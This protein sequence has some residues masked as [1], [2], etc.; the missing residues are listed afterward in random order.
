MKF[1][2]DTA[3][4]EKIREYA[5]LG[6]VDGVTTN[7]SL[8]AK[9]GKDFEEVIKE[10][11]SIIKGPISA[12]VLSLNTEGM[13]GEA[14][15]LANIA[16]NIA[17]KIPMTKEGIKATYILSQ[18]GVNVNVTLVFSPSQ[19]LLAAKV[20]AKF[21]SPFIGRLDDVSHIGMNVV[22]SIRTIFDNYDFQTEII[23]ASIRHPRHI[24]EAAELGADIATV[25]PAVLEKIFHHPLT[26]IGIER[27]LD[28]WRKAFEK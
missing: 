18:K 24:V 10:I 28:D 15:K 23:V 3:N 27:F 22:S 21:V 12:E 13:I 1:F 20:G 2:M 14:K 11:S 4:I 25:P 19:A 5:D 8:V 26:D 16:P 17:I 6:I 7:P 9:E